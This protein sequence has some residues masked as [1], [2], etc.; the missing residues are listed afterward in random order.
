M[1]TQFY[2]LLLATV[3]V[4]GV[5]S[6]TIAQALRQ[7]NFIIDPYYGFPNFGKSLVSGAAAE[8][9]SVKGIGPW[10]LRMEYMAG[11]QFGLT[12]DGIHNSAG[13]EYRETPNTVRDENGN[14]VAND[15]EYEYKAMMNRLRIQV[16]FNYHFN[17]SDPQLD[18]YFGVAAGSNK[19]YWSVSTTEPNS[20]FE[21]ETV[22]GTLLPVSMRLRFGGRYYFSENVGMN[23]ELG[24]GGPIL[25]AG[26]SIKL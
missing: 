23:M 7:G 1:K 16:G 24:L 6:L 22:E 10:G 20:N 14:Q 5:S 4:A 26:L 15:T 9:T 17:F 8:G 12:L 11:D 2:K 19:R 13:T 21:N 25:S 18:A 3:F